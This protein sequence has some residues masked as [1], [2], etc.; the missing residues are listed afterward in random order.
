[1]EELREKELVLIPELNYLGQFASILRAQG[2]RAEAITQYDG[3]PF[4][5]RDIVARVTD[6]IQTHKKEL[7]GV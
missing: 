1:L 2:V 3:R 5:V 6:R 7:V 4:K